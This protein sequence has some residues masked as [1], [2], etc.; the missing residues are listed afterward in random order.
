VSRRR[1][2]PAFDNVL[3]GARP[4]AAA[5]TDALDDEQR[6]LMLVDE[7]RVAM[8]Q[9]DILRGNVLG[10]SVQITTALLIRADAI[11]P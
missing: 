7:A 3:L 1:R 9:P 10:D 2:V 8:A 5:D 11:R 4:A 6:Y